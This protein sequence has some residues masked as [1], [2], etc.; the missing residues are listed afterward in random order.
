MFKEPEAGFLKIDLELGTTKARTL[1]S[2]FEP[3]SSPGRARLEVRFFKK[4]A[5]G[6]FEGGKNEKISL[7]FFKQIVILDHH[8]HNYLRTH[9]G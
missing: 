3:K 1:C 6:L 8:R 2:K 4:P 7:A 5:S 9:F